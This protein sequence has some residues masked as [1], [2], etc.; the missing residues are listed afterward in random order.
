MPSQN[1][2][3]SY[4]GHAFQFDQP[5]PRTCSACQNIT[6]RNPIP[7]AVV[8]QPVGEE[9]LLIRRAIE[10][11]IGKWALPGGYVDF[12]ES[13]Q[14][15]AVRE[16][17]EE[18]G[19]SAASESMKLIDVHVGWNGATML[20]F[21]EAPLRS[22]EEVSL[23]SSSSEVSEMMLCRP[24]KLAK[25]DFAFPLHRTVVERWLQSKHIPAD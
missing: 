19:L 13:W 14:E 4:C 21:G 6:F 18:T 15:A 2:H 25:V 3:C 12:G 7:V 11:R 20:V 9:I 10:P 23:Q 22:P 24:E 16:L 17:W 5:W 8:V 1:S